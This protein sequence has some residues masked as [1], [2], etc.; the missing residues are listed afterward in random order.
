MKKNMNSIVFTNIYFEVLENVTILKLAM[1]C[2][3]YVY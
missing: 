3:L 2:C 1:E